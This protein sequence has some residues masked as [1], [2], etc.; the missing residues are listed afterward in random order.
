MDNQHQFIAK[1]FAGLEDI[2]SEELKSIGCENVRPSKRAV[3]F[4]GDNEA[5]YKA[6]YSCRTALRILK[7]I[8][9]FKAVSEEELYNG[10]ANMDWYEI[11]DVENTFAIDSVVNSKFFRHSK[12]VAL[13]AKDAVVD[14]F[15][16]RFGERPSVNTE[17]PDV[18]INI[19][20]FNDEVTVALDSSGSSLHRRGYRTETGP[21]PMNEVLAAGLVLLSGWKADCNFIDPMCGSGTIL[22]EAAMLA[23]DIP[24]G[25]YRK[26]YGFENWKDF[27]KDIWE[28]IKAEAVPD[29]K[30]FE[31]R[32][33]GSDISGKMISIA[34]NNIKNARMHKDIE[35]QIMNMVDY[36]PPA[37]GGLVITNPPYGE[38][39]KLEDVKA[40]YKKI[41][42][43]LKQ[44]FSGFDAW[45]I[46]SDLEA[47]KFIGL[48]PSRK[49]TVF[50]GPLECRFLKF[51]IYAGSKKSR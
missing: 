22:M 26:D 37:G 42:D 48:R 14:R 3:E 34:R 12:Y 30:E 27:D 10:I 41:G 7:T 46:T 25:Y 13:K 45:L 29:Q 21:A 28:K 39:M 8:K 38:R 35:L 44:N 51:S 50:N 16:K 20:I 43:T 2:L 4:S 1:T 19:R 49:I 17:N 31:H 24:P 11:F 36:K 15:R 9:T 47:M 33:I 6:N 5:M 23:N 32:I 40:L 18:R